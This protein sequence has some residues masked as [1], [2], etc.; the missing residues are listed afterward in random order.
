M[1]FKLFISAIVLFIIPILIGLLT[2]KFLGENKNNIILFF[3][4]GYIIEFAICEILA[5]PMIYLECSFKTLL[6]S[7]LSI[8]L[9]LCVISFILNIRN[10]KEII[11]DFLNNLKKYPK[12]ILCIVII[13][14]G[15]QVYGLF[16][17][18]HEDSDDATYVAT[19][20]TAIQTNSLFKYSAQ[21]G[22]L[23]GEHM[24]PRY[25]LGPFPL[26]IA[27][28]SDLIN[29]HP[30]IVAHNVIPTIF[31]PM[32]YMIYAVLADR[33]FKS[34]KK[35]VLMFL[36]IL[37]ILHIWGGYSKR[38]NFAFLLFRIWQGKAV[39]ASIIIPLVMLFFVIAE[40]N[41][42]QFGN[43]LL[44]LITIL[45]GVLT[46]TMGIAL[47]PLVLMCLCFA[48]E[49]P[50]IKLKQIKSKENLEILR[51]ILKCLVCCMPAIFYGILYF[52]I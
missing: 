10:I 45:G 32:A 39:L 15:I 25:R 20:T 52:V 24:V 22:E 7:F 9:G 51:N 14:V 50:K 38:N 30:A 47:P 48:Y 35:S 29:I 42:Y 27:I 44:L 8:I 46:T 12:I 1:I 5:V 26:Y 4:I 41:K 13:L 6:Y 21:T 49:I 3:I 18:M 28:I 33:I 2:R 11:T 31:I 17:Y 19:A 40:E 23:I 16:G 43:C 34:N 37:C 36:L